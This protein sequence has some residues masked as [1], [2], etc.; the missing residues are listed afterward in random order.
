MTLDLAALRSRAER[1]AND[2]AR[3]DLDHQEWGEAMPPWDILAL[4]DRCERAEAE[5]ERLCCVVQDYR[6]QRG[7]AWTDADE[8]R[9]RADSADGYADFLTA[10][11]DALRAEVD[12]MKRH[13]AHNDEEYITMKD[14]LRAEHQECQRLRAECERLRPVYEAACAWR[15]DCEQTFDP[16]R[17]L[18][19]AIDT[20]RKEQ[21][22]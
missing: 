22:K 2:D 13:V 16:T 18:R 19:D 8:Q 4:L 15:D 10:E 17:D 20:A 1:Y 11:R 7:A 3:E 12:Q 5:V 9:D 6:N 21:G 14:A